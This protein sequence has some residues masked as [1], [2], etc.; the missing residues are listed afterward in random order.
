MMPLLL[1]W[2]W[3]YAP[4]YPFY[5]VALRLT[6]W[7]GQRKST[8]QQH[9]KR[10]IDPNKNNLRTTPKAIEDIWVNAKHGH[11]VSYEN[12]SH[13]S[14]SYQDAFCILSTGGRTLLE[15]YTTCDETVI[16]LKKPIVFKWDSRQCDR[17]R[18]TR[19]DNT[20]W[21]ARHRK[22]FNRRRS[23]RAFLSNITPMYLQ[24]CLMCLFRYWQPCPPLTI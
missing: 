21:L 4:W 14:A 3:V 8:A 1:G 15:P 6:G 13:L 9:L 12:V 2:T 20:Y 10:L 22:P 16:E 17:A 23:K 11:I 18:L 24:A 5:L 19:Q 7:T